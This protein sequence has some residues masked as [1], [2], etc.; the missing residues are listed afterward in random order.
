M[1]SR[2]ERSRGRRRFVTRLLV[3][4]LVVGGV[5]YGVALYVKTPAYH[6]SEA[7]F[8]LRDLQHAVALHTVERGDCPEVLGALATRGYISASEPILDPWGHPIEYRCLTV[9]GGRRVTLSSR[10]A[11]GRAD[12][13]DDV[14]AEQ[15]LSW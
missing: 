2:Q 12:T 4:A 1:R 13:E 8:Q 14:R 3:K 7:L 6:D 15:R 9:E 10:G 11:D 5:A